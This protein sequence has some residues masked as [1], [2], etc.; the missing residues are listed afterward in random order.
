MAPEE[1]S[2][3]VGGKKDLYDLLTVDSKFIW[4]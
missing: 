1:L 4:N 3:W 2:S